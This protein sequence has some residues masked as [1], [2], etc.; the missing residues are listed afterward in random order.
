MF[1]VAVAVPIVTAGLLELEIWAIDCFGRFQQRVVGHRQPSS[2]PVLAPC[3]HGDL[4]SSRNRCVVVARRRR[5]GQQIVDIKRDRR[6]GVVGLASASRCK[7][8]RPAPLRRPASSPTDRPS[9]LVVGDVGRGRTGAD[10]DGRVARIGDLGVERFG[11]FQQRIVGDRNRQRAGAGSR[12][13]RKSGQRPRSLCSRYPRWRNRSAVVEIK[14]DR[15]AGVVGLAERDRVDDV[16]WPVSLPCVVT[17]KSAVAVSLSVMFAV[18]VAVPIVTAG[19]LGLEI[20]AI[21]VSVASR[22]HRR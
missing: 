19:L 10:R 7:R 2:V 22:T 3:C 21:T 1:A 11:R 6:A 17:D 15:R 4:R 12:R 16:D 18:A 14:R 13:P 9:R 5:T 8:Y 20:W